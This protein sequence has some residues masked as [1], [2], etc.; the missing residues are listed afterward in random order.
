LLQPNHSGSVSRDL[1]PNDEVGDGRTVAYA[2]E[3]MLRCTSNHSAEK[4]IRWTKEC[5]GVKLMSMLGLNL[6]KLSGFSE[7]ARLVWTL[8]VARNVIGMQVDL[9]LFQARIEV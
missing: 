2:V 6:A 5:L 4:S 1:C 8:V 3:G 9:S 7:Q